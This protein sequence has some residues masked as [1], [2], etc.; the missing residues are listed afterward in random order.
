MT[1]GFPRLILPGGLRTRP[2]VRL[3]M[4]LCVVKCELFPHRPWGLPEPPS[5]TRRPPNPSL[6]IC[7]MGTPP[8]P[9][10]SWFLALSH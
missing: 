9:V 6:V 4:V 8:S 1:S 3:G 10:H 7:H 5:L 2:D